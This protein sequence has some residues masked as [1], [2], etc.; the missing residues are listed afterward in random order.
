[1][2]NYAIP[3]FTWENTDAAEKLKSQAGL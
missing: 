3:D 1:M 2:K